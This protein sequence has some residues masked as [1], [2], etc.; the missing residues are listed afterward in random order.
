MI[1]H[2]NGFPGV[3]KLTTARA[4]ET[5]MGA[6]LIDNH[7]LINIATMVY[8]HGSPEYLSLLDE[9][10]QTL[11]KG[12]MHPQAPRV[13]IFTNALATELSEDTT[14]VDVCRKFASDR[15]DV[16]VPVLLTCSQEA[17]RDRINKPG[18]AERQKLTN[19]AVLDDIYSKYT[20][21]HPNDEFGLVLDNTNS[22]PEETALLIKRHCDAL[23]LSPS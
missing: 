16:F 23:P 10:T 13:L 2:I 3:G 11:Y 14:R 8:P 15:G 22:Q 4:L 20:A 7:S 19:A 5:A 12:L 6:K 9:F 21:Y 1:I 18:R 17:N